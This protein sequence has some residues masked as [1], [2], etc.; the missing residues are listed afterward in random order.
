MFKSTFKSFYELNLKQF[1]SKQNDS[2]EQT[3]QKRV[4]NSFI[5]TIFAP[6]KIEV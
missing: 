1:I 2:Q 5:N 4:V 3:Q 6:L